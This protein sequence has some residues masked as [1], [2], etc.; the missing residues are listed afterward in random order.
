MKYKKKIG[1]VILSVCLLLQSFGIISQAASGSVSV[2]S[3]SGTVGSNVTVKCTVTCSTG[4]IGYADV[5]LTYDQSALQWVSGTNMA[6]GGSGSVRY[7]GTT[8]DGASKSLSFNMTFSIL[9]EG[10]H[11]VTVSTVS[12]SDLDENSFAPSKSNGTITGT[13][14]TTPNP[15]GNTGGGNQSGTTVPGKDSNNKLSS[16][17]VY[18]GTLSPTF[19]ASVK[20]YNVT[21]SKET[22]KVTVSAKAQSDKAKVTVSGGNNLQYGLNTVKVVVVAENGASTAYIISVMRGEDEKI[23]LDGVDYTIDETFADD[24]IPEGFTRTKIQYNEREYEA[25]TSAKD[26]LKLVCLK[27]AT[28][29][30]FYIYEKETQA[31]SKLVLIERGEGKYVIPLSLQNRVDKYKNAEVITVQLQEQEF[32]AWKLDD[33]FCL[34]YAMNPEGDELLYRYDTVEEVFQRY[35][36]MELDLEPTEEPE[37]LLFPSK[38]YMYA[39]AGLGGLCFILF[40]CMVYF[41]ASRKHRHEARKKKMQRKL[42]KQKAKE[43]KRLAKQKEKEQ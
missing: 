1:V 41:I 15:G 9:K 33:E 26:T 39:I 5:K 17:K 13:V 2:G 10:S 7:V 4:P 30:R 24:V 20:S 34:V 3:A 19:K 32:E 23:T 11:R 14:P 36:D 6:Q 12:A 16:L 37:K 22:T 43:E 40:I 31:F 38:Y 21:V 25:L 27:S 42:E 28:D 8:S 18:P 35:T 29:S